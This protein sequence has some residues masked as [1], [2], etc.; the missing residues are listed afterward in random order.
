MSFLHKQI[1]KSKWTERTVMNCTRITRLP[2]GQEL[3]NTHTIEVTPKQLPASFFRELLKRDISLCEDAR[4]ELDQFFARP[5]LVIS[6]PQQWIGEEESGRLFE[7]NTEIDK[8]LEQVKYSPRVS[9]K[10]A[11]CSL[12]FCP[13]HNEQTGQLVLY[14]GIDLKP[15][16]S[17]NGPYCNHTRIDSSQSHLKRKL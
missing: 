11:T 10:L 1:P 2:N 9:D 3:K 13:H 5:G 15:Q 14:C 6:I 17:N 12:L 4:F 7:F 8:L 16:D